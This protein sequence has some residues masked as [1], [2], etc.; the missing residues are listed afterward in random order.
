LIVG[1]AKAGA[2][3]HLLTEDLQDGQNID[4]LM[5]VSPFSSSPGTVLEG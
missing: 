5:V 2:C 3:T 4:G 1:A